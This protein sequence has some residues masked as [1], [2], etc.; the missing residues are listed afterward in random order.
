MADTPEP[1]AW[2]DLATYVGVGE[3]DPIVKSS[4]LTAVDLVAG[5][6]GTST[7]PETILARAVLEVGS[8]LYHRKNAPNG[9]SNFQTFEAA[10]IRVAR[11]PMVAARP[12]LTPYLL[13]GF[14]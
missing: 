10:P 11:D 4:Y 8:E 12:L 5:Y 9:V 7:V 1:P 14:A 2:A 13:P 6:V 3:D